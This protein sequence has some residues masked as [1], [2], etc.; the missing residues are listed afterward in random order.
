YETAKKRWMDASFAEVTGDIIAMFT[1]IELASGGR[2][3]DDSPLT[4]VLPL[5]YRS[6]LNRANPIARG[7]TVMQ[8]TKENYP[9]LRF[10]F[11]PEFRGAN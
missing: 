1:R 10:V 7:E 2:I 9:N 5:G 3:K 11:S 8:W 6:V 4:Q